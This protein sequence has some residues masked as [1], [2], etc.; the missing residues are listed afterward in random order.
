MG[1][2][3]ESLENHV[4]QSTSISKVHQTGKPDQVGKNIQ[5]RVIWDIHHESPTNV[6]SRPTLC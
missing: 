4:V 3:N 1:E 6:Q 2:G 5:G